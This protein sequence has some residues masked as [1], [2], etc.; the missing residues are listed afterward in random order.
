MKLYMLTTTLACLLFSIAHPRTC[1]VLDI[2]GVLLRDD[3]ASIVQ[4]KIARLRTNTRN[5]FTG[6]PLLKKLDSLMTALRPLGKP[7]PDYNESYGIPYEVYAVFAGHVTPEYACE[8]ITAMLTSAIINPALK[9]D[10]LGLV[11]G[12]FDNAARLETI[13]IIPTGVALL[14]ALL[15]APETTV[16]LYT[17]A[18]TEWISQYATLFP[19]VFAAVPEGHLLCSGTTGY[20]KPQP[21]A[22]Q[23]MCAALNCHIN[24]LMLIDDSEANCAMAV[25][26][27]ATALLF[28]APTPPANGAST[29]STTVL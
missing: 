13:T 15:A 23:A 22:Y 19:G 7:T 20:M 24:E 27:G 3:I 17:N 10:L 21:E 8:K 14:N 16:Y 4:Q 9:L 5:N 11:E 1:V 29:S 28:K 18:P 2:H 25:Q 12:I 26:L 6:N